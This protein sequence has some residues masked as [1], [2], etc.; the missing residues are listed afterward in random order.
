MVAVKILKWEGKNPEGRIVEILD[1][2]PEG[3][4]DIYAIAFE[5]GARKSF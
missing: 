1:D 2:I 4:R 5:M 3:R